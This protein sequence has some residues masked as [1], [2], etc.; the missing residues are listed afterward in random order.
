MPSAS[1]IWMNELKSAENELEQAETSR[2]PTF[3]ETV[4]RYNDLSDCIFPF[5]VLFVHH[6]RFVK[7]SKKTQWNQ[8]Y[9]PFA[10]F[11]LT[12]AIGS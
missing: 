1:V 3:Q 10:A 7:E 5:T 12:I 8:L 11:M 6:V 4:W 2:I 9:K